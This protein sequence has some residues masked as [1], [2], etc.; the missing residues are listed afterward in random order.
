MTADSRTAVAYIR[1]SKVE[2]DIH[3]RFVK[4]LPGPYAVARRKM[5]RQIQEEY[6]GEALSQDEYRRRGRGDA[7]TL[8]LWRSVPL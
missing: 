5:D 7:R 8:S 4:G 1:R 6:A 2:T 3:L